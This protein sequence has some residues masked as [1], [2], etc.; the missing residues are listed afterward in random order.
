MEK[1]L[2]NDDAQNIHVLCHG[3]RISLIRENS[4]TTR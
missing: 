3:C 4:C 1:N 2:I